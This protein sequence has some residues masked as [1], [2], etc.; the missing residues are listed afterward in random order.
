MHRLE[1]TQ[2]RLA[3]ERRQQPRC[4]TRYHMHYGTKEEEE[5]EEEAEEWRMQNVETRR[6]QHQPRKNSFTFV[7]LPSFSGECDP[8]LY[9]GWEAKVEIFFNVCEV[10]GDQNSLE[11]FD[12]VMQWWHQTVMHIGLNKS[13]LGFSP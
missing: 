8:N 4:T 5:E 3:R 12:Y 13:Y 6:H 1:D 9:L 7:K 10:E 2:E 11:F